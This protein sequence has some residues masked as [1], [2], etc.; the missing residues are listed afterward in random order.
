MD[1][2]NDILIKI[3]AII[4]G[5]RSVIVSDFKVVFRHVLLKTVSYFKS[6]I[7][8]VLVNRT[9]LPK[10]WTLY[11]EIVRVYL[12]WF[13]DKCAWYRRCVNMGSWEQGPFRCVPN[14]NFEILPFS[15]RH[16]QTLLSQRVQ[17]G[18]F[19]NIDH[20][21]VKLGILMSCLRI[22]Q[23]SVIVWQ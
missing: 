6:N 15:N 23:I 4:N 8:S 7:S 11:K 17:A 10:Q 3:I 9:G 1:L 21:F 16:E 19:A 14:N 18:G 5:T 12:T 13:R 20:I 22:S 2:G